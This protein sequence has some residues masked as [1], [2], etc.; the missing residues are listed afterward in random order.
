M[1][2]DPNNKLKD[3]MIKIIFIYK[4]YEIQLFC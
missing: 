3:A 2:I 4:I 1:Y